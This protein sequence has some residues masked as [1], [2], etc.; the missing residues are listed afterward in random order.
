VRCGICVHTYIC[1][2]IRRRLSSCDIP[3]LRACLRAGAAASLCATPE[4][5]HLIPIH[6]TV[7][8]QLVEPQDSYNDIRRRAHSRTALC[9]R[10]VSFNRSFCV[11]PP[12]ALVRARALLTCLASLS[13]PAADRDTPRKHGKLHVHSCLRF[14]QWCATVAQ[15]TPHALRVSVPTVQPSHPALQV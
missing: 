2:W 4:H 12:Q 15:L 1:P 6:H 14:G 11:F 7:G 10:H 5:V 3:V 8:M 13:L 9:T